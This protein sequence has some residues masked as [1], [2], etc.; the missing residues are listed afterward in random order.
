MRKRFN[1]TGE[2]DGKVDAF[3]VGGTEFYQLVDNR[4][5]YWHESRRIREAIKISK[6]GDGNSLKHLLAPYALRALEAHGI[7]DLI[8][9]IPLKPQVHILN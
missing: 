7:V 8:E 5:Y 3:G 1:C 4:R 2:Y 6:V 9:R